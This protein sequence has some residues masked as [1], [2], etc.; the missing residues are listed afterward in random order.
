MTVMTWLFVDA[1]YDPLPEA[2]RFNGD[3][4][5][6]DV[7]RV[8]T[9]Y[10]AFHKAGKFLGSG[11]DKWTTGSVTIL[12]STFNEAAAFNVNLG[13]WDV[14]KVTTLEETFYRAGKFLGSGLD[15]W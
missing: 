5:K 13:N 12:H 4:S 8:N 3:L 2:N 15:K 14:S 9:M 10:E 7:S 6:W 1:N 11:L